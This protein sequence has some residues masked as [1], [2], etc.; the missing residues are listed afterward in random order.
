MISRHARL[1]QLILI[2]ILQVLLSGCAGGKSTVVRSETQSQA[3]TQLER[4]L[5]AQS[6]GEI[7]QAERYLAASLAISSSIEDNPARI[8]AHINL[9]RLNRLKNDIGSAIPHIDQA[10][11]LSGGL[12]EF[13]AEAAYEKSLIELAQKRYDEALSWANRSFSSDIDGVQ[14]GR[15]HNLLARIHRASG[16]RDQATFFALKGREESHNSGLPDEEANALRMLG[17]IERE[18]RRFGEAGK[19]LLEALGIDKLIGE[20]HKIALDLEELAALSGDQGNPDM[21]LEYLERAFSVHI[22]G[23]RENKAAAVK[24][25]MAEIYTIKGDL[26]MAEKVRQSAQKLIRKETA[27]QD[28]PPESA[29][30][31]RRP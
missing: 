6:K 21:A 8:T 25:K 1:I 30:P 27:N 20:S 5:R 19:L 18:N 13:M 23:S 2:Y 22:N 3:A 14:K 16:N 9:A 11:R 26:P 31:S 15:R 7:N 12:P 4:G 17:S 28:S 10:L 24:L 29:N